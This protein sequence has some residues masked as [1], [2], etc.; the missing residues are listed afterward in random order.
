MFGP[1]VSESPDRPKQRSKLNVQTPLARS[2][3]RD[4][5]GPTGAKAGRNVS[6]CRWR[7]SR[8]LRD[9]EPAGSADGSDKRLRKA[10]RAERGS[11]SRSL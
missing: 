11:G 3:A 9:K 8:R 7:R 1:T 6:S 10:R 4:R 2:K 5:P